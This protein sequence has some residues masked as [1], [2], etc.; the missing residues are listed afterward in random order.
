MERQ[1]LKEIYECQNV[2]NSLCEDQFNLFEKT[3]KTWDICPIKWILWTLH[4]KLKW[5]VIL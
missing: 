2:R 3:T 5:R 4:I 1:E